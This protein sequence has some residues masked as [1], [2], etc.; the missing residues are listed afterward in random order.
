MTVAAGPMALPSGTVTFLMSDVEG[1]SRRWEQ[2]AEAM[3]VAISRH[4]E[5]MDDAIVGHGGVRPVEQ[6]EGDSV[7][8][9]F[10]RASDAVAAA[11]AAQLCF[12]AEDWPQ[13]ADLA[14]RIAVHTG[15]AHLRDDGNYFGGALNRCSRIRALGHGG[16]VLVSA[17]SA[18]L[19]S[20]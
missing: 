9:A 19:V 3:A 18:T 1:S 13:G 14:V 8:G 2:A 5:L 12:A 4:Y 15:E 11:V 20:E 6:G 7:V 17:A 16:Q 10:S